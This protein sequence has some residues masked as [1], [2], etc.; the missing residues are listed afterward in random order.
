METDTQLRML[1]ELGCEFAQGYLFGRPMAAA[2]LDPFPADDLE[3]WRGT[4]SSTVEPLRSTGIS[5]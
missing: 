4:A 5:A 3:S 2:T 1:R